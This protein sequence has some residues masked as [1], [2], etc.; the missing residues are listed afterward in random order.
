LI[1]G[2]WVRLLGG[3]TSGAVGDLASWNGLGSDPL[4]PAMP[5]LFVVG[6]DVLGGFFAINGG[7]LGPD[8]RNVWYLAP[9]T[10]RWENLKKGYSDF[11]HFLSVGDL[12]VF[13]GDYR[14][15]GWQDE[16]RTTAFDQ[17]IHMHPPLWTKEGKDI[18]AASRRAVPAEELFRLQ[19]DVA[20]QLADAEEGARV[21]IV[22]T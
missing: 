5:G 12:A 19:L 7:A 17:A 8:D 15:R 14:W 10:A 22:V 6:Y 16:V 4:H 9:D 13:Y 2:G 20:R 3:G 1:D 18:A 11:V 21:K